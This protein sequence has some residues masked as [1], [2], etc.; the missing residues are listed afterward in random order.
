MLTHGL[1]PASGLSQALQV[2][3][4][5]MSPEADMYTTLV[6]R[7]QCVFFVLVS[8]RMRVSECVGQHGACKLI[9]DIGTVGTN[10]RH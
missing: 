5:D 4:D 1:S 8:S 9:I 3:N 6:A 2:L 7:I 10:F